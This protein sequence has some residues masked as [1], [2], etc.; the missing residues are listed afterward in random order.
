LPV[1]VAVTA[2]VFE[3]LEGPYKTPLSD[4]PNMLRRI[5]DI[6]EED[7]AG[8]K[9]CIVL[10]DWCG[11]VDDYAVDLRALGVQADPLRLIGLLRVA[12][13]DLEQKVNEGH[14][15]RFPAT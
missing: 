10:I 6:I 2:R 13:A 9:A 7:A 4:I 1:V 12:S 3:V 15:S 14:L 5:A 11:H 8:A